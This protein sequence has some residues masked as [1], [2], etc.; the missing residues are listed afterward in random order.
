MSD[1]Q[2]QVPKDHPMMKAW[3][4][5]QATDEFKNSYGWATKAIDFAVL[6]KPKDPTANA[7]THDNYRNAVKGSL[8]AAFVEGFNAATDRAA[9]LH[10]SINPAS[11]AER[12]DKSPGAGAMGAVVEYRDKIRA[13]A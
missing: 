12:L 6:P 4:A 11:D 7:F 10:E 5:Y 8:W 3:E 9:S 2:Q 1:V 13:V